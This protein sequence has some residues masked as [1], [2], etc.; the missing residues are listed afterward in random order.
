M[1]FAS[2]SGYTPLSVE[3]L[4][5]LVRI[6]INE[7][8]GTDYTEDSFVGTN[9]YK[10]FYALIQKVQEN[11]VLTS[12]VFVK[13][14]EYIA[15]TNERI[16]RPV[17]T[18]PGVIEELEDAGYTASVKPMIEADAGK[19]H[20]CVDLTDNHARG[21]V[22]I[23]SYANL[24]SGTDDSVTVGATVFTAQ[25][26]AAT[27]G[28]GTFQA[29]T[30]NALTAASLSLQINSHATAG[31]LVI[32]TVEDAIVTIRALSAGTAGN[33]IVLGYTDND[34]N[35]GATKSA[36]TLLGGV[37]L[38]D[39]DEDYD[40]TRLAVATIIKN[41][42]A[43]GVVTKG[44]EVESIVLSN[45]QSFDFRYALPNRIATDLRL[46]ITLSENN[47][48]VIS[49]PEDIKTLLLA[50]IAARYKLGRNF[51]PQTYFSIVD[52]PWASVVLLEYNMAS[53]GWVS[54]VFNA[55]FDDLLEFSL[56]DT[57]VI[58]G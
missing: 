14:Q 25:T 56:E 19:S 38:G 2:E 58:E 48:S 50:N 17:A 43:A 51:E 53:A 36:T 35:V 8:F 27:P 5:S 15:I 46:T 11:E 57:T 31:A 1:S 39:D 29:A 47:Q 28:A 20:V 4:M 18:N 26:G 37:A 10:Y 30:S 16:S 33:A 7:Q 54:T 32:A 42:I 12:E 52:A 49:S 6:N 41:S 34:T 3:A 40:D 24:V 21:I 55:D 13:L 44:D 23:T 45:G 22:T 9:F